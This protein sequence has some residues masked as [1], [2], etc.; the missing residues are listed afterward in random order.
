MWSNEKTVPVGNPTKARVT[1]L[2]PCIPGCW[3]WRCSTDCPVPNNPATKA[4]K[5]FFSCL[6][7]DKQK[8]ARSKYV[9]TEACGL[10]N[11]WRAKVL[12]WFILEKRSRG[13]SEQ[14][15]FQTRGPGGQ[16]LYFYFQSRMLTGHSVRQSDWLLDWSCY[17]GPR[18]KPGGQC[19][20]KTLFCIDGFKGAMASWPLGPPPRSHAL[21]L[22]LCGN[23]LE[24]TAVD[25]SWSPRRCKI[26]SNF[27]RSAGW[28]SQ[29]SRIIW[30]LRKG[31]TQ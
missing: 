9:E 1:E 6:N 4:W 11:R 5:L 13:Q 18:T 17:P 26:A 29:Q 8:S 7:F 27:G 31:E 14:F 21:V 30:Y 3:P 28:N 24:R 23:A 22:R 15:K 19:V 16:S 10:V 2:S 25:W 12:I 20:G